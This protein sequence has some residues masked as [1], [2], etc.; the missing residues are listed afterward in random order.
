MVVISETFP[1][2]SLRREA[3]AQKASRNPRYLLANQHGMPAS[4]G[5]V[6]PPGTR[7]QAGS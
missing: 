2:P 5:Q 6:T 1:K 7:R 4:Q 3:N